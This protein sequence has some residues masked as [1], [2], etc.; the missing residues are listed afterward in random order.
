MNYFHWKGTYYLYSCCIF[1]V[2]GLHLCSPL[3]S[4]LWN[5][6]YRNKT[7]D[8]NSNL[9]KVP[10]PSNTFA[11]FAAIYKALSL[12]SNT[13]K[14]PWIKYAHSLGNSVSQFDREIVD[15]FQSK[16]CLAGVTEVCFMSAPVGDC[17]YCCPRNDALD[18]IYKLFTR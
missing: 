4:I 10:L 12:S 9:N 2:V 8:R 18:I 1:K 15:L 17:S 13:E 11:I 7:S 14:N 16:R 5:S 3:Y 6:R